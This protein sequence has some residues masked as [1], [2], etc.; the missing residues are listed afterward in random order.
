LCC[1]LLRRAL[2]G[3]EPIAGS[4]WLNAKKCTVQQLAAQKIQKNGLN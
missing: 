3:I 4:N 2:L 1:Q